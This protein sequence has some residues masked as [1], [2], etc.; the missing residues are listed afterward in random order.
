M[1]LKQLLQTLDTISPFALQEEWDNSGLIL[2]SQ[3]E[4][5]E[6]VYTALDI[7]EGVLEATEER[8]ALVVH[9]PLLFRGIKRLDLERFPASLLRAAIM[10]RI[11]IVA[12][13][14]NF[15]KS[16]LN[17]YVATQV[18]GFDEVECEDFLCT[19][20]V[21]MPFEAFAKLVQR[22]LGLPVCKT[23]PAKSYIHTAALCTG[24]GAELM[25]RVDADCLLTGD[26]KYHQAMEARFNHLA[27]IEIGHYESERYFA[28]VLAEELKNYGIHAIM[29]E[30]KNPFTYF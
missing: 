1:T 19:F 3:E 13:H 5:I 30:S 8:S 17:R 14:T 24:S 6:R 28:Q 15:D 18:L 12:M 2:G 20:D 29:A 16:H 4:R 26:I 9:H 11:A 7:D 27:M 23:V 25:H 10:K 22:R 21:Q